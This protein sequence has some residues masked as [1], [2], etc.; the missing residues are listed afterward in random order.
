MV[1]HVGGIEDQND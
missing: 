1:P